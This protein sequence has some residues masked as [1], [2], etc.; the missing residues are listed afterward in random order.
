VNE[1]PRTFKVMT[2]WLLV[3]TALFL[4]VQAYLGSN[5]VPGSMPTA[6]AS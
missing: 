1:L 3:G 4:A 6:W 2:V 5:S